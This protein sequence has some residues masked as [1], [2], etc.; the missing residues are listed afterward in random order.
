MSSAKLSLDQKLE[1][2]LKTGVVCFT[3]RKKDGTIRYA[4]GTQ[5]LSIVP[6][7][8]HPKKTGNLGTATNISYYDFCKA[9]FRSL[10]RS[11]VIRINS[12]VTK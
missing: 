2:K 12:T 9:N 11:E 7:E 4:A 3:F 5:D 6:V 8:K 1:N 10:K